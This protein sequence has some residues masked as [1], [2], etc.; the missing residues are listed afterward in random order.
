MAVNDTYVTETTGLA[1]TNSANFDG[2][3]SGTGAVIATELGGTGAA[4]IYRETD[5]AGDGSWS[6][7]VQI[8]T[9]TGNWHTQLNNLVCN[10]Q[11]GARIRVENTS[12]SPV[13]VY[14][15]GKETD[16]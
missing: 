15:V 9:V 6:V 3:G 5:P 13:D 1:D 2:S 4:S 8:D 10:G 16:A 14:L 11:G 7:T 12:G